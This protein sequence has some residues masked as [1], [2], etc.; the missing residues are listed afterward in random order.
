MI[1]NEV[2]LKLAQEQLTRLEGALSSLKSEIYST[3]PGLFFVIA[4]GYIAHIMRL[5]REIDDYTGLSLVRKKT[6]MAV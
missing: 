6:E 2:Q 4:E 5:R 3:N 1:K